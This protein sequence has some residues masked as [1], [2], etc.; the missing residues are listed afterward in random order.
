MDKKRSFVWLTGRHTHCHRPIWTPVIHPCHNQDVPK[1]NCVTAGYC[2]PALMARYALVEHVGAS[3][4]SPSCKRKCGCGPAFYCNDD[5]LIHICN[6]VCSCPHNETQ[7]FNNNICTIQRWTRP[8]EN[9]EISPG[10]P[11]VLCKFLSITLTG[12]SST[13]SEINF[14]FG[15]AHLFYNFSNN[16]VVDADIRLTDG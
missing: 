12:R 11:N 9:R 5:I 6:N 8:P 7:F 1:Q 13:Y 15:P 2:W 3:V 4:R 10:S 16:I 14:V